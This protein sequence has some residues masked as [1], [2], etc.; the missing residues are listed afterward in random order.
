[1]NSSPPIGGQLGCLN[2]NCADQSKQGNRS[3]DVEFQE[4][5]F[6][7][8]SECNISESCMA[9]LMEPRPQHIGCYSG[10]FIAINSIA[11]GR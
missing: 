4:V 7:L 11:A 8:P 5:H 2:R 9:A 6:P 3:F 1:M 10:G